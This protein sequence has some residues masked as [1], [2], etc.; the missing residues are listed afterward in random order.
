MFMFTILQVRCSENL[1]T[2]Q[3]T[4]IILRSR[5][6]QFGQKSFDSILFGNVINLP[7]VH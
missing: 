1:G 2:I 5:A 7:L 6:S 4:L 3:Q